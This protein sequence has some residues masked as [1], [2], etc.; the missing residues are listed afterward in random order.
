MCQYGHWQ[1][2]SDQQTQQKAKIRHPYMLLCFGFS[3][4][5][6]EGILVVSTDNLTYMGSHFLIV[7]VCNLY[8]NNGNSVDYIEIKCRRQH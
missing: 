8:I 7:F 1:H 5:E 6:R 2:F 4:W 3:M